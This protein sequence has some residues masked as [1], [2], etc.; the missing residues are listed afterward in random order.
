MGGILP[1]DMVPEAVEVRV[2]P[3]GRWIVM[4]E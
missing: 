2:D 4:G 1:R 3:F